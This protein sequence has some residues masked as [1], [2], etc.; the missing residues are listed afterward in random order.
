MQHAHE[1]VNWCQFVERFKVMSLKMH[2][3][4]F[5]IDG[6]FLHLWL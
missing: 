1:Y 6:A 5:R 3:K 2:E 4:I